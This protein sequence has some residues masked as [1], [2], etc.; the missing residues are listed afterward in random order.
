VRLAA[1]QRNRIRKGA[2]L[3]ST[4]RPLPLP[5]VV[6][7]AVTR[8]GRWVLVRG[9]ATRMPGAVHRT[10]DGQMLFLPTGAE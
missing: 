2:R 3:G 7:L 9:V 1:T 5:E 8:G 4:E 6:T 10:A